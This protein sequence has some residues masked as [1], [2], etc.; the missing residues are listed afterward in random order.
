[1]LS[2][3]PVAYCLLFIAYCLLPIWSLW[4]RTANKLIE[5]CLLPV[6]YCL[7]PIETSLRHELSL[8]LLQFLLLLITHFRIRQV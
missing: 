4:R 3:L 5:Y 1:M 7:F 2:G 6:A 8:D